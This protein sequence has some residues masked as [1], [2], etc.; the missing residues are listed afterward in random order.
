[1]D[2]PQ[3]A[4]G[5]WRKVFPIASYL[6]GSLLL[7]ILLALFAL[8]LPPVQQR[9]TQEVQSFLQEKLHSR[10]EIASIGLRFPYYIALKGLLLED[11]QQDTLIH[12]GNLAVSLDMWKLIERSIV[13][14]DLRLEDASIYLHQKDSINNYDFI[15]NAFSNPNAE[16]SPT[17]TGSPWTIGL[18]LTTMRIQNVHFWMQDADSGTSTLANIG[19]LEIVLHKSDLGKLDFQLGKLYLQDADIQ[20]ILKQPIDTSATSSQRFSFSVES[21]AI[22]NSHVLYAT[23]EQYLDAHL[24]EANFANL[25]LIST[26]NDLLVQAKAM[27]VANSVI[28]YRDATVTPTPRHFNAGDLDLQQLDADLSAFSYQKDSLYLQ[29]N[30]LSGI[31]KSGV[32]IH[33]LQASIQMTPNGVTLKKITAH[34]NQTQLNGEALL[35]KKDAVNYGFMQ[36]QLRQLK[37]IVGDL[38]RLMPP[39]DNQELAQLEDMPYEIS[40]QIKGWLENMQLNL[41]GALGALSSDTVLAPTPGLPLSFQL[42]GA[43][44]SV[45]DLDK[46]GMDLTVQQLDAQPGFFAAVAPNG[47]LFPDLLQANGTLK[48]TLANLQTNLNFKALRG[49]INSNLT[50]EGLL[51][52]LQNPAQLG[53]DGKLQAELARAEIL[54]FVPSISQSVQLPDFVQV[55]GVAKGTA[56]DAKANLQIVLG[57]W[58]VVDLDGALKDSSYQVQMIGQNILVHQLAKDSSLQP[59]KTIGMHAQLAGT[60]FKIWESAQIQLVGKIDSLSWDNAIFRDI[61]LEGTLAGK[62]FTGKLV[63]IDERAAINA[64]VVGDF[65]TAI[66]I[67]DADIRLNCVDLRSF[68]WSNRPTHLCGHVVSHSEG[69]SLDT[70][71]ARVRIENLDLQY[72]TVHVKPGDMALNISL[73]QHQNQLKINS[74]WLKGEMMGYFSLTDLPKTLSNIFEQYFVVDRTA[75]VPRVSR[76]SVSIQLDLLKSDVLT[77]GLIPG[78]TELSPIHLEAALIGQRNYFNLLVQ[79]PRIGY[80]GWVLDSMNVR[81]YAGDSAALFVVTTP[82]VKK[83]NTDFIENAVLNGAFVAN[84]ATVSFKATDQAG[85]ERFLLAA[86]ATIDQSTRETIVKLAP[87]QLIDFKEWVV[88]TENEIKINPTGIAVQQLNLS[89]AGQSM[90]LNGSTKKMPGGKTG[91]DF[92]LDINRLNYNNF[93]IFLSDVLLDLGG[94]AEARISI[95]GPTDQVQLRGSMQL[96]ETYFTPKQTNVRY[97][98]SETPLEFTETGIILDGLTLVDPFGKSLKINGSVKTAN[99]S[100]I[101]TELSLQAD[102]WQV[103]NTNKQ[104]NPVY[105]G[106]LFVSLDGTIQG[107]I[108]QPDLKLSVKTAKASTFTYVYDVATQALQRE[109]VVYFTQPPRAYV[110][111]LIYDAPVNKQPFTLSASIEIDS[112]LIVNSVVNPVT[113][114]DFNG[115]AS[116]KLQLDVL[117]N[118]AMTLVGRLELVR[119]IYNYAYQSVVK[120]SFN[121]STGSSI[122]WTGDIGAPELDIKARYRFKASPFPLVANQLAEASANETAQYRTTQTFFLQTS[123][124]GSVTKPEVGFQFIYPKD[125]TQ[126]TLTASFGN[127]EASLVENALTNVNQ[128]KN[129]LSRQVFGVLLLRNFIGDASFSVTSIGGAN[130]LQAGLTNFLTNQINALADQYL[131]WID[132]D[133]SAGDASNQ[134][135]SSDEAATNYQLRLQKSFFGDRLTFKISGGT[136]VGNTTGETRSALEN[137]SVEYAL[138]PNGV[139]KVTVFSEQGFELLNSSTGNLRNSGAG[140]IF[141]KEFGKK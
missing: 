84:T 138:T 48:G 141:T 121:V 52:N 16:I 111:P 104:Q 76:D 107:P 45:S 131:T 120:R 54:G 26:E 124:A 31:D 136:T 119:G 3:T 63:S 75:Y 86:A 113:G 33:S 42:S 125:D 56:Q 130:P 53:F 71:K 14:R 65:E 41:K 77:T 9:I 1:M 28:L 116:G 2:K 38:L 64:T 36:V 132:I 78:L 118:G 109:G 122:T 35:L 8:T 39:I 24:A 115:K 6:L 117:S 128:D 70:L 51:Q 19:W 47:V 94:W 12:I 49:G 96:H 18:D 68:G 72:D 139:F 140:L 110:R 50:F 85:Q 58:G 27:Q 59:L 23:T 11:Q 30:A 89:G 91:L 21:G 112:N 15:L 99:W 102:Q 106:K 108:S 73:D 10:V 134:K 101:Q 81:S 93:D 69:L 46:L 88:D 98:L 22:N 129:Q 37:G 4:K 43:L 80:L 17:Q 29:A 32:Q 60:G 103:L 97:Q 13:I 79:A 20:Y 126:G 44:T 100:D 127:Q 123:I 105:Y 135:T 95:K 40:G 67:L 90:V 137:A 5:A 25:Y 92:T 55:T 62:R 34:L 61:Q 83:G 74:D 7:L 82:K 87:R 133:L 66:P 114:D 57:N